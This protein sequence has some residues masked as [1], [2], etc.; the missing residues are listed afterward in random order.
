MLK[1]NVDIRGLKHFGKMSGGYFFTTVLNNAIPL[2]VLPILTRYLAPEE[3]ANI[4][5][6]SF[7]LALS[8]A[9][10]GSSIPALISKNFFD[11]EKD[12]IARLIG[13]S[14]GVVAIFSIITLAII[15]LSYPWLK[16]FFDLSLIWMVMLPLT[17]LAWII[18]NMGL[19]VMRNNKKLLQFTNHQVG[20]TIIN[21]AISL[22]FIVVLLWGWQGRIWGII[23]S[24]LLSAII[25]FIYLRKNGYIRFHYS[26]Q[27][28]K[29]I[30]ELV[31]PMI[32]N[33]FQSVIISQVGI[34][35][36]QYYFSKELL[37]VYS[38]G[39]Q[40]AFS[41]KLLITALGLSWSP[42][43]YQQLSDGIKMN[44]VYVTRMFLLLISILLAGVLFINIF[45]GFILKL[46]T[47]PAYFD[48]VVFVPWLTLGFFFHGLYVFQMPI[49]IKNEKQN[50]ISL[51]SFINMFIMIGLNIW[52][53]HLFGYIG[54]AYA[55]FST[56][57]LMFVALAWKA[58]RVFPLPWLSALK[59][60]N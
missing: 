26:K 51:V 2:L 16:N 53:S 49:L 42:F 22:F 6:F 36:I 5:L 54:I 12:F 18:F 37:G 52:F 15:L 56:Y 19:T 46:L 55:Y 30:L 59:V 3:Y 40:L 10:T 31:F 32:P 14:I 29:E 60:W 58:Q 1:S 25:M 41:I 35:F 33:S 4:A 11:K 45:A 57:F 8:N 21:I 28:I 23:I 47:T 38:I 39:F 27:I 9:L 13:N 34:F 7:Y 50:Y 17:S 43:M 48:A 24:Y 44:R 20:N